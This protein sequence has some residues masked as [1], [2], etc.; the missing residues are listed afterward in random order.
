MGFNILLV[1]NDRS[2]RSNILFQYLFIVNYVLFIF[3]SFS[4]QFH[5]HAYPLVYVMSTYLCANS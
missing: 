5:T 4:I 2:N 3:K 1:L